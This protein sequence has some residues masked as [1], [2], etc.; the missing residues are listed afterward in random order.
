MNV[1]KS[2]LKSVWGLPRMDTVMFNH[3]QPDFFDSD[4]QLDWYS[5]H[6]NDIRL[7][8][9]VGQSLFTLLCY[10]GSYLIN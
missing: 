9:A 3:L 6:F 4:K 7:N 10:M 5:L 2:S 8:I 1:I